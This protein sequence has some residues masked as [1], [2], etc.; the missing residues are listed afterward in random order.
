M[1]KINELTCSVIIVTHN[2]QLY[3]D[4]CLAALKQQTVQA[5]RI[6]IVDSGSDEI[7]YLLAWKKEDNLRLFLIKENIGFCQAN[8]LGMAHLFPN[9]QYVLF[10]N[11]DA[12]LTPSFLEEA[13]AYM[14]LPSSSR[15]GALTGYL[16]GYD[17]QAN[18]PTGKID[19][20]GIF[21][22]WYGRW[23]DRGQGSFYNHPNGREEKI[24]AICGALMFCRKEALDQVTLKSYQVMDPT[25]YMYKE[26][27]DLSLRLRQKGWSLLFVP[28]LI[29][30]HCRGWKK[31][32]AQI[33]RE[34]RLLSA[35]NEIF[36]HTR[37]YSPY[38]IY[39]VLKYLFVRVFNF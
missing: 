30:Y 12:F 21:Q 27:I 37:L 23:Y 7:D 36:L 31:D 33:P 16:L 13:M 17:I 32:R 8:N 24:P 29:S 34:L 26:D 20:T 25:F 9:S 35:R 39:S 14:E 11:P 22:K 4:Q 2:S 18:Q 5:D 15:V 3:L 6:I 1:V 19:S 38:F 28:H 10:L